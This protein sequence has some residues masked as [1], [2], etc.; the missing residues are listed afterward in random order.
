[1]IFQTTSKLKGRQKISLLILGFP[2]VHAHPIQRDPCV[3]DAVVDV[4]V[5]DV[6]PPEFY[7]DK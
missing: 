2:R 7:L 5:V 1:M 3:V 4:V 6:H